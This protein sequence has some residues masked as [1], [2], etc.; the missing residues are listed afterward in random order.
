MTTLEILHNIEES[1]VEVVCIGYQYSV[2]NEFVFAKRPVI[3][4]EK[5][6]DY[7]DVLAITLFLSPSIH[8]HVDSASK[9]FKIFNDSYALTWPITIP[10]LDRPSRY[11][12]TA[13]IQLDGPSNFLV[14]F[15]DTGLRYD[16]FEVNQ[17]HLVLSYIKRMIA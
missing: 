3:D 7:N 13:K 4:I 9:N 1:G 5:F 17:L 10:H 16:K 6:I 2:K 12:P 14:L 11:K 15:G 8:L